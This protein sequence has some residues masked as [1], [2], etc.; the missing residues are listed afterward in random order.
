MINN[1]ITAKSLGE[2][3]LDEIRLILNEAL[4][5]GDWH[6]P[7]TSDIKI[8]TQHNQA[9]YGYCNLSLH[10][11]YHDIE[12][13]FNINLT[14]VNIWKEEY[15]RGKANKSLYRPIYNIV[16]LAEI[17]KKLQ[18]NPINNLRP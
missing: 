16:S 12:Y 14:S 18:H 8:K 6:T 5:S 1:E 17:L 9:V 4:D 3:S 11:N 7:S 13:W 15:V 10:S 2:L